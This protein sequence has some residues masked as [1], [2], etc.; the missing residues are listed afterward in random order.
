MF[1]GVFVRGSVA[2]PPIGGVTENSLI[3]SMPRAALAP[4][5][6]SFKHLGSVIIAGS[7]TRA[8]L[9]PNGASFKPH[10]MTLN[11]FSVVNNVTRTALAPNGA[12]IKPHSENINIYYGH[13]IR[14]EKARE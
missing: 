3:L 8:A 10:M 4:M 5:G 11:V 6:A 14:P 7:V 13:F 2:N 1:R 12:S 9:T